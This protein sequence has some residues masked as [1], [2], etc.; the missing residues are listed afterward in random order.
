MCEKNE[1]S[2]EEIDSIMEAYFNIEYVSPYE[3]GLIMWWYC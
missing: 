1:R 3:G 2:T